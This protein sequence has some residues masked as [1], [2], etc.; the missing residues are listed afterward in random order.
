[1]AKPNEITR[2]VLRGRLTMLAEAVGADLD[3]LTEITE[4]KLFDD[5]IG[6]VAKTTSAVR[7]EGARIARRGGH[8][9]TAQKIRKGD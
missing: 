3:L 1:M 4:T 9:V 5:F 8:F 7:E 2:E 6:I